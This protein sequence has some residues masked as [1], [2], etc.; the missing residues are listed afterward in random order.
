MFLKIAIVVLFL[1]VLISLSSALVF[2]L[3]D[4]GAPD[5]KRSMYAL[6][7]RITLAAS[8]MGLITY[9][10]Y[11]GQLGNRVPWDQVPVQQSK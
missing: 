10:I 4:I 9:G 11:S 2:L 8:L 1:G 3:K 5:K 7:I 6:G